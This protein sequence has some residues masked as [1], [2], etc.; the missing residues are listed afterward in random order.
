M[1]KIRCERKKKLLV[2]SI[3]DVGGQRT[4]RRKWIHQFDDCKCVI[5]VTALSEY[6]LVCIEDNSTVSV[7]DLG[8]KIGMKGGWG[9]N[10]PWKSLGDVNGALTGGIN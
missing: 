4:E 3:I 2:F 1:R 6:D 7:I 10:N 5:F 8:R 9:K